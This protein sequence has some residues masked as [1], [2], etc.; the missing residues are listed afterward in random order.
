[1]ETLINVKKIIDNPKQFGELI[2]MA[3]SIIRQVYQINSDSL[4]MGESVL[5][6]LPKKIAEFKETAK[7]C[8]VDDLEK[9]SEKESYEII[10]LIGLRYI[11]RPRV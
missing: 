10:R 8:G 9:L 3:Q 2:K 5:I 4:F 1:L 7:T 11:K 6:D